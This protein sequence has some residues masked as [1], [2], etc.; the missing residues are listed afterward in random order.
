VTQPNQAGE[1]AAGVFDSKMMF[2]RRRRQPLCGRP[3][4]RFSGEI[5][6]SIE[7]A[8]GRTV[9]MRNQLPCDPIDAGNCSGSAWSR[10]AGEPCANVLAPARSA[11]A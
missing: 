1:R 5:G 10:T 6:G 8:G 9:F 3:K 7:A 2:E 11:L 4:S